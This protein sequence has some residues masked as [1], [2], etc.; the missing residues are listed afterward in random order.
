MFLISVIIR[1]VRQIYYKRKKQ[2]FHIPQKKCLLHEGIFVIIPYF[3][4]Y[5]SLSQHSIGHFN[6]AG[7][8]GA[9]YVI[10]KS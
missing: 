8:I 5:D 10:G 6:K 1:I 7:N 2:P 4:L 9:F 3:G